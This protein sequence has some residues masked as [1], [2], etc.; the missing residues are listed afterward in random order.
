MKVHGSVKILVIV[1]MQRAMPIR[2]R[3][4]VTGPQFNSLHA[5]FMDQYTERCGM[6]WMW[7]EREKRLHQLY[8]IG[9]S[10][11]VKALDC[12]SSCRQPLLRGIV[13]QE[14]LVVAIVQMLQ[15]ERC[16]K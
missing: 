4:Y 15:Q 12:V 8:D 13:V 1:A 5:M 10:S 9:E 14:Y 2:F 16:R 6:R 3:P 11:L 7:V